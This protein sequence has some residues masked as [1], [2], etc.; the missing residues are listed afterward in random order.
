LRCG[1][2]VITNVLLILKVKSL[3]IAQYLIKLRR[4][5]MCVKILGHPVGETASAG[6]VKWPNLMADC[7]QFI[8]LMCNIT[9][10]FNTYRRI[11]T[12]PQ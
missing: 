7:K 2:C 4:T 10:T 1:D 11:A 9:A 6:I 5:K 3:K 8:G 12:H